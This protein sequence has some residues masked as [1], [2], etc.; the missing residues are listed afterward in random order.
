LDR[1]R[2]LDPTFKTFTWLQ[3][4][5]HMRRG[6]FEV[7]LAGADELLA[8]GRDGTAD[9][10]TAY[11]LDMFDAWPRA[12]RIDCLFELMR[13]DDVR[14]EIEHHGE[15]VAAGSR[16]DK[17]LDV[18]DAFDVWRAK[19]NEG[20]LETPRPPIRLADVAFI[21]AVRVETA[22]RLANV[23]A[24][25]R[26]ISATYDCRVVLGCEQPEALR[27]LVPASVEVIGVDGHPDQAFHATRVMN[28]VSRHVDAPVRIHCDT[29]SLIP[30]DQ[31]LAAI[32]RV[33]RGDADVVLPFSFG[34]GVPQAERDEF[35]RG[36]VQLERVVRPRPMVGMPPGLCQVWSA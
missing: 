5:Q 20:T 11:N 2:E 24:L 4:R 9:D 13:F 34:I 15:V 22:D 26:H 30:I 6:D 32:D 19:R 33:R 27:A 21:I 29:D 35:A 7:A 18:C 12:A 16:R 14:T 3:V 28:D 17:Q 10:G 1:G 25:T 36:D 23:L 8:I 31:M